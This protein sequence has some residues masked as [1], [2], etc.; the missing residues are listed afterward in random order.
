MLQEM[1][2]T[3]KTIAERGRGILAA[4]E[5]HSTIG[6]RFENIQLENTEPNRQAYREM[7]FTAPNLGDY[8]SGVILFEETLTQ[9]AKDGTPFVEILKK[10]NIVPGIKVDKGLVSFE[11]SPEEKVTQGLDGLAD[12]LSTYKKQGAQFAKWRAV[13]NINAVKPSS[14][15]IKVN[16]DLL[17]RYAAICQSLGIVP[18][19]EPEVLIDG[20][21]TMNRCAEV[22][23]Q[24]LHRVFH[25]LYKHKV[26]LEN[27]I[28]KPSMVS[29][30]Q[31]TTAQD[32]IEMV[33][34]ETMKVLLRTTP[35]AV[36]TINF[37]SG[38]HSSERSTAFLNAMHELYPQMPWNLSYSYGRAL[39]DHAL[40]TW[41]GKAENIA[42]AQQALLKRARLNSLAAKGQYQAQLEK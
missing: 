20:N 34:K 4:D 2:L 40:K 8:I 42:A 16:A 11:S 6:K 28:L 36:P 39:Q 9:N 25:S 18:I 33:A 22:T 1:S 21:H 41:A 26:S 37:L 19:V 32:S 3:V 30:G 15:A 29:S 7:L 10:Q 38:G 35:A 5:S 13:F 24:V 17:A 14:L 31:E 12:R 27:M 23:E